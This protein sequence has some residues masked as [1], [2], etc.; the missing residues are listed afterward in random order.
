MMQPEQVDAIISDAIANLNETLPEEERI[1]AKPDTVLFGLNAEVD[2]LSL[3]AL[4]VDIESALSDQHDLDVAL[5]DEDAMTRPVLPF[6]SLQALKEY[7]LD[8]TNGE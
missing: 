6:S 1:D 2:S 3:V 8:K 4:I 7:I 5:A